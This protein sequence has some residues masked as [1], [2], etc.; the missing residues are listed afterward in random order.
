MNS[1]TPIQSL[2]SE[3]LF[4]DY[5][6]A[7]KIAIELKY[8]NQNLPTLKKS[9]ILCDSELNVIKEQIKLKNAEVIGLTKD[10]TDL[11]FTT[12]DFKKKLININDELNKC[13]EEQPSRIVWFG[14]GI[15]ATTLTILLGLFLIK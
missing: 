2:A 7:K 5:S 3:G 9:V 8:C 10:K 12:N 11:T 15:V 4:L 6:T 14:S 13:K 1:V